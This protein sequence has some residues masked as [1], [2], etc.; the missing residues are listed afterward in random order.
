M[1]FNI[2]LHPKGEHISDYI[3]K[4]NCWESYQS[5]LLL[6]LKRK[7]S[8]FIFI[9]IGANIGYYSL[10]CATHNIKCLAFEP[11]KENYER[12]E[13]SINENKFNSL[14]TLY[15]FA[16]GDK[17]ENKTFNIAKMN[18][19]LCCVRELNKDINPY[20]EANVSIK[21]FDDVIP[22]ISIFN[23]NF[24][25]KLDAEEYELEVLKGMSNAFST[26]KI[27]HIFVEISKYQIELFD[28]LK[29][30][31]FYIGVNIGY[32]P[33]TGKTINW[34][35]KHLDNPIYYNNINNIQN[36]I[37]DIFKSPPDKNR[38]NQQMYLFFNLFL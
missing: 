38:S 12:F 22:D 20:Q 10:L 13:N 26:G 23:K 5:E 3:R 21:K 28:I 34:D 4:F 2:T 33:E 36:R 37:E 9:D 16:L 14:I 32:D 31:N 27:S 19:G 7:L 30:Y 29:R 25:L 15:K 6:E 11:I 8:D 35:S 24:I 17:S 1:N 18:M